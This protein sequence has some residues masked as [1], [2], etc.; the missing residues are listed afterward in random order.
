MSNTKGYDYI[1]VG[2]GTA[3]SIL[4][5]MLS[6]K[7]HVLGLESGKNYDDNPEILSS[8]QA[9]MLDTKFYWKFFW[10]GESTYDDNLDQSFHWPGGRLLG[11]CSSINGEQY[12]KGTNSLYEKWE[13]V[14]GKLWSPANVF[15]NYRK[16]ETYYGIDSNRRGNGPLVISQV[17][18]IPTI[19]TDKIAKALSSSS[20]IKLID[21]YNIPEIENGV[22]ERWQL[23]QRQD[24]TRVSSSN[25]FL[26]SN[27]MKMSNGCGRGVNGHN[28]KISF[29]S[30]VN[31]MI[32]N[33][34]KVIGVE[35]VQNG[36]SKQAYAR[37]GVIMCAGVRTPEIL[38][39]SGVGPAK[40]LKSAGVT[41]IVDSPY[42]GRNLVNQLLVSAVFSK[43]PDDPAV[44]GDNELYSG[45]AFLP[46]PNNLTGPRKYQFIV[47]GIDD[48]TFSVLIID[49][50]PKSKG[51]LIIQDQDPYTIPKVD[52]NYLSNPDDIQSFVIAFQTYIRQ[53]AEYINE[54]PDVYHGYQLI[55][56]SLDVIDDV[57]ALTDYIK[58]NVLQTHH[59]S[60]MAK[61]GKVVDGNGKVYGAKHLYI[62]DDCI[63]PYIN[64][65]N[66][67]S[68]AYLIGY[69]I[70]KELLRDG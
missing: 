48:S 55:S 10:L 37:K 35:Y 65:G 45:G 5:N 16:L 53:L 67:Q 31:R 26:T 27:V 25:T 4:V 43:N 34:N 61:M 52:F 42:L 13:A 14:G 12:V 17:P 6:T 69:T 19:F 66:T 24:E 64:N 30:T 29:N 33:G 57:D 47:T 54:H 56:P 22:F 46:D 38:Q 2:V 7:Y 28:F 58:E 18:R 15:R 50:D 63:A 40:Q 39:R 60:C 51:N 49:L 8:A 70:G 23:T 32:W 1:V 20:K 68:T 3:G 44:N 62:A 41:P 36:I 59:I 21:D 11:G 9:S